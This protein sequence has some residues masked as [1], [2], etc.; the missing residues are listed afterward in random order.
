MAI[1]V[2]TTTSGGGCTMTLETANCRSNGSGG[3]VC[4]YVVTGQSGPGC[5]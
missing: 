3:C 4:D 2:T 5:R 1:I